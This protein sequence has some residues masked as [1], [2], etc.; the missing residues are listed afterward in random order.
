[1]KI[2]L[3]GA[4]KTV[5]GSCYI[6]ETNNARFAVD[7]GMHQ[8][9]AEIEKRNADTTVYAAADID[10]VLLTHA[11][12]D[13][14]G[15]LPKIAKGGFS[16]PAYCTE[17][18]K[19]LLGIMLLDS[20]HIQETEAEWQSRKNSRVGKK[21]VE[22]LYDQKDALKAVG[23]LKGVEYGKSFSPA[24]GVRVTY[25]D[26]GHI[27]G[28]AFLELEVSEAEGVTRLI[29]SGDLGR[30]DSLLMDDP[31]SPLLRADYLFLE[32]T[33]GDRDHKNEGHSRDELAE[34]IN[35]AWR[36][37]EKAIIPAFAV[38]RTQEILYT[39]F[40]LYKE[41]KLPKD[42]PIY[43][44]SPLAIKATKIFSSH[45]EYF[46]VDTRAY[47]EAGEDPL[48]PPN[49][50]Y[51]ESV[52]ESQAV[53]NTAGPGV[54]ISASGMCNAGRIKHHLRHN[55]WKP[56]AAIVFAGYQGVGTPGRK[57]VDGAKSI[58]ILG[59][60]VTVAA[61]VFT[62]GGFSGHAGQSQILDWVK[63]FIHKDLKIFLVHGEEKSIG[64]LAGLLRERFQAT[65]TVP[66][67]REELMLVP[68]KE[69]LVQVDAD[70]LPRHIRWEMLMEETKAKLA[71]LEGALP[72]L[73]RKD[74]VMQTEVRDHWLEMNS[75]ISRL[76]SEL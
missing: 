7:C 30:P 3:L 20:A 71:L 12:I 5:T 6:V 66:S 1:M 70:A 68:G 72:E 75:R 18:T 74:W 69:V 60:D 26:A 61:K 65:V 21:A 55:L 38:E 34:A 27:L 9:N 29:F 25:R 76:L 48:A 39:L 47:I 4:A 22:P 46:D 28:S 31:D 59:D 24:P 63:A 62:I 52:A 43:V 45:P 51:T 23:L 36:H 53:N 54:V 14:S 50:H 32:S 42:L 10:F 17:P 35:W 13:H 64:V 41:G 15:L 19:D 37:G 73:S 40:L 57:I 58:N 56:G 67:Y 16:G 44:D 8:G 49:L 2:Q 11:H 33:Y